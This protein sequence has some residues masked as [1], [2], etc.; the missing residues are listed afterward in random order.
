MDDDLGVRVDALL[1]RIRAGSDAI[2]TRTRA[3]LAAALECLDPTL[4]APRMLLVLDRSEADGEAFAAA[5]TEYA[6]ATLPWPHAAAVQTLV[7]A[8]QAELQVLLRGMAGEVVRAMD[9]LRADE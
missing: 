2:T 6:L 1:A 7:E 4:A 3:A 8:A 5:L 9:E